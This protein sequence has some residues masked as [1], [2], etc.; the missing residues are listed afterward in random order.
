VSVFS[1]KLRQSGA[2]K[3]A[4]GVR[5]QAPVDQRP[6]VVD[7]PGAQAGNKRAEVDLDNDEDENRQCARPNA[8]RN[9]DGRPCREPLRGPHDGGED[10]AG[11]RQV[12]RQPIL[13]HAHALGEARGDHPP[14]DCTERGAET[15]N[16]P[17]PR[18]QRRLDPPA[19]EKPDKRNEKH[20][21]DEPRQQPVRPFP[22]IDR[23]EL[24]EAHLRMAFSV[25]WDGLVLVELGLP[26]ARVERRHNAGHRLPFH[27]RQA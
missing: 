27:D 6:G 8:R 26:C 2:L 24:V 15:E 23:L 14:A 11:E 19:P 20:A 16:R 3:Q 12:E 25:L 21:P 10:Q 22:P 17:Q 18:A 7:E 1:K 5:H 13:R 4:R 9:D